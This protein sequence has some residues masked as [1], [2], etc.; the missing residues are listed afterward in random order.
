[1]LSALKE[2]PFFKKL[3]AEDRERLQS[4]LE[5]NLI[6]DMATAD[7]FGIM[8]T[9]QRAYVI[10]N[11]KMYLKCQEY[12]KRRVHERDKNPIIGEITNREDPTDEEH[13]DD[14]MGV[15]PRDV[16]MS[17][18]KHPLV[19]RLPREWEEK[20]DVNSRRKINGPEKVPF[21]VFPERHLL[22][23]A[24]E[25]KWL[26]KI[27]QS[28][29][30]YARSCIEV[31]EPIMQKF[32]S[33]HAKFKYFHIIKNFNELAKHKF[34]IEMPSKQLKKFFSMVAAVVIPQE[35]FGS[36]HNFK[37]I[38]TEI[39][40]WI[41]SRQ[42]FFRFGSIVE[43]LNLNAVAWLHGIDN[44]TLKALNMRCFL[45]WFFLGYIQTI[46]DTY[47]YEAN[48]GPSSKR[49]LIP[50][51]DW[52]QYR[53]NFVRE[54]EATGVFEKAF[55]QEGDAIAPAFLKFQLKT[56]GLRP[57]YIGMGTHQQRVELTV[58]KELLR[59][60][61]TAN[62]GNFHEHC[63]YEFWKTIVQ[64]VRGRQKPLYFVTTDIIDA[65]GSIIQD[66]LLD[67]SKKLLA[68][69]P[70]ALRVH[71][72]RTLDPTLPWSIKDNYQIFDKSLPLLLPSGTIS[73]WYPTDAKNYKLPKMIELLDSYVKNQ[74]VITGSNA[75]R[76]KRGVGQGI[77]TSPILANIYYGS[78]ES[79]IFQDFKKNGNLIRYVDDF[80]Y[81]TN[82]KESAKKFLKLIRTGIPE[83]NCY[84]NPTKTHTNLAPTCERK[85][86]FLGYEFDVTTLEVAP[87]YSRPISKDTIS[88]DVV[89]Q[90]KEERSFTNRLKHL[91][92]L[93]LNPIVLSVHVNSHKRIEHT[94]SDAIRRAAGKCRLLIVHMLDAERINN[95]MI[96]RAINN[97]INKIKK[98]VNRRCGKGNRVLSLPEK[99]MWWIF[100]KEFQKTP[101][102]SLK[103]M[104]KSLRRSQSLVD[105]K[106]IMNS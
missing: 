58:L 10:E 86:K 44:W 101:K 36:L 79:E 18:Y 99:K 69:A 77:I 53:D 7:S 80:L 43:K 94:L 60:S 23:R 5:E 72:F 103:L 9:T 102:L 30:E 97:F 21:V 50:V 13:L 33:R 20:P 68:K 8:K 37:T 96:Y 3:E 19:E 15:N 91:K 98:L 16:F 6:I 35:L 2:Y 106:K 64:S 59:Q 47:F 34:K 29:Y 57:V 45:K 88:T 22:N 38:R 73:C 82:D 32:A 54:L 14:I 90:H 39:F 95:K 49:E 76:L 87:D 25:D 89:K 4:F 75:Y 100:I 27:F 28:N 71:L 70:D 105:V 85:F 81:V 17:I 63:L 24:G 83:Y 41:N 62:C 40:N 26:E 104:I 61:W 74:T 55:Y 93:K 12:C 51:K 48:S 31:L 56:N 46:I 78:M 42:E 65:F 67:I 66:K 11:H 52:I 84:F 92:H 1:M